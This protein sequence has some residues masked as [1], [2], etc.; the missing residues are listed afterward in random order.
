M[1][2]SFQ[3]ESWSQ[4]KEEASALWPEHYQEV[5]IG[6]Q[7]GFKLDPDFARLARYE[8]LGILHIVTVRLDGKLVGY[9]ASLVDT[10]LHYR[11]IL[12][13]NSD[14]YWLRPD[15]RLGR[16]ALRL[17]QKVEESL[18]ARGVKLLFDGTKLELDRGELFQ[19]LGYKEHERRFVK[20]IG[21]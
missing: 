18:R 11:T 15:L 5:G 9:H 1:T 6:R 20:S 2:I 21:G 8:S 16:V 12:V 13:G 10:L 4:C 19:Y 14:L 3:V 7:F 17:F